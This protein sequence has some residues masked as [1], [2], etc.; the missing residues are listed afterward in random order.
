MIKK[1]LEFSTFAW[2]VTASFIY[3]SIKERD[4]ILGFFAIFLFYV[5]YNLYKPKFMRKIENGCK[6]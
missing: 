5:T 2:I 6:R 3:V 1:L 4:I